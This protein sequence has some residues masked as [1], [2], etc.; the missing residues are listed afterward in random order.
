MEI[1][2]NITKVL[3]L[4]LLTITLSLSCNESEQVDNSKQVNNNIENEIKQ[5]VSAKA[6]KLETGWGYDIYIDNKRYIHQ[7]II[8]EIQG[9]YTFSTKEKAL[10]TANFVV[11]KINN[12][13]VPPFV[14]LKELDSL[15]VLPK[16]INIKK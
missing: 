8:P 14:T 11:E 7:F 15:N 6:I 16:N 13:I 3:L 9:S 12:G 2:Y 10:K 5:G 1:I 4:I